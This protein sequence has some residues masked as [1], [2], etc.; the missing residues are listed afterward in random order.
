V[1]SLTTHATLL[2]VSAV[3]VFI[4]ARGGGQSQE[5]DPKQIGQEDEISLVSLIYS[6]WEPGEH[7]GFIER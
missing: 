2:T 4:A 1:V 5:G 7:E 6:R 3:K